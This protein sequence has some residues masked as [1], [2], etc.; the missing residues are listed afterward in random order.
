MTLSIDTAM[1]IAYKTLSNYEEY[2]CS[3]VSENIISEDV[4]LIISVLNHAAKKK[5]P[6]DYCYGILLMYLELCKG[7]D[8]EHDLAA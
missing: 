3:E 7:F 5:I 4:K 6:K 2:D 8:L 1:S